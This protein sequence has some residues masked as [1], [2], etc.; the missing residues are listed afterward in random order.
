MRIS[1]RLPY[2]ERFFITRS[3]VKCVLPVVNQVH[4][5]IVTG[6]EHPRCDTGALDIVHV[7][8]ELDESVVEGPIHDVQI[9]MGQAGE[10]RD[11]G[12]VDGVDGYGDDSVGGAIALGHN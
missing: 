11:V 4:G 2:I 6:D 10:D 8:R 1:Y 3:P 7:A 5:V 9:I 12:N